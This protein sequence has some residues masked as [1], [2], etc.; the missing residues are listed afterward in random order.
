MKKIMLSLSAF[1]LMLGFGFATTNQAYAAGHASLAILYGSDLSSGSQGPSTTELQAFLGEQGYLEIAAA[2]PFGYF[3]GIT[4]S[5]LSRY[6]AN[7]NVPSTG[8]FGPMTRD[9]I[10]QDMLSHCWLGACN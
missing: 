1:A 6:Q 3:G 5:A 10:Q 9:A 8:Y 2:T 7:H 4:K